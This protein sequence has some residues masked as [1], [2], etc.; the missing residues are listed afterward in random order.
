MKTN[1]ISK[2]HYVF[3]DSEGNTAIFVRINNEYKE[4]VTNDIDV[5]YERL[6]PHSHIRSF[7]WLVLELNDLGY[8]LYRIIYLNK[9]NTK[10]KSVWKQSL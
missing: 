8:K 2:K 7:D 10:I 3:K 5:I 9:E 6:Y 4:L 1:K